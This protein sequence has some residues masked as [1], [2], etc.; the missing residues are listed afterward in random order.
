LAEAQVIKSFLL[1][2]SKKKTFL[3][4]VFASAGGDAADP[5][6]VSVDV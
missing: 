6:N 4:L 2:F 3:P 1:L 5:F